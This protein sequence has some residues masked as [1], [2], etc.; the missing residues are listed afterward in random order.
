MRDFPQMSKV[1]GPRCAATLAAHPF[2]LVLAILLVFCAACKKPEVASSAKAEE[3][4]LV[5][6]A[7]SLKPALEKAA[8][9]YAAA[10]GK[11]VRLLYGG[12]GSLVAS[13]ASGAPGDL[14]I[15]A[16]EETFTKA[17]AKGLLAEGIPLARQQVRL[18]VA[19]GNPKKITALSDL[20]RTDIRLILCHP[21]SAS[22]GTLC[23]RHLKDAWAPLQAKAIALK[24]T[25]TE[26]AADLSVGAADATFLWD[27]MAAAYPQLELIALPELDGCS[28]LA[29]AG[30]PA[31]KGH[32]SEALAFARFLASPEHGAPIWK[33][34]GL[35]PKCPNCG[36]AASRYSAP[37][38]AA[39]PASPPS[40]R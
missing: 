30:L 38:P 16:D 18:A 24:P 15:S 26:V 19:K 28:S 40:E 5:L 35:S 8:S 4:L 22:I 1:N 11:T 32:P 39:S 17:R 33:A 34:A 13:L 20:T 10:T 29:I 36:S 21:D 12:S 37:S 31:A 6:A 27:S 3:P 2:N 9:A 23:R 25:V 7:A 14:L